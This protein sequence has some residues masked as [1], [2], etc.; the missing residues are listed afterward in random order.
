[1]KSVSEETNSPAPAEPS[2]FSQWYAAN[3]DHRRDY[4]RA[5]RTMNRETERATAR[6][7]AAR[8]RA[9]NPEQVLLERARWRA[10]QSGRECTI[11]K[12]DIIIP[13]KC[14][15]LGMPLVQNLG[16]LGKD[17]ASLDRI[18]AALG[19]IPGNVWVISHLANSMKNAATPEQLHAFGKWALSQGTE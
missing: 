18:D 9:N 11:T 15:I 1:M 8:K 3:K 19:Y 7:Y 5:Y 10:S 13:L 6:G 16:K 17:S 2:K 12:A 14:P 4:M